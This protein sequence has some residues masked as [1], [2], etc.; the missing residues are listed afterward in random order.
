MLFVDI[1]GFTA[2]S[3][4]KL[5][6]DIVYILNSFFAE[7]GRAIEAAGGRVDKYIGDGLMAVFEHADGLAAAARNA[8]AA[9]AA[10]DARWPPSTAGLPARSTRRCASRWACTAARLVSGRIG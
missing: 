4:A 7:A 3:E 6:F 2:L 10:V 8:L 5:A 9:V 1:R